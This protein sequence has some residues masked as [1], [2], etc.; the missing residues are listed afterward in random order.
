[1][2]SRV[3]DKSEALVHRHA[4]DLAVTLKHGFDVILGQRER[5]QIADEDA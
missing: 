2:L 5:V 4:D 1:M 3:L